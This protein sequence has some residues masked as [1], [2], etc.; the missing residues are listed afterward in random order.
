MTGRPELVLFDAGGTLVTLDPEAVGDLVEPHTG[1]RPEPALLRAAHYR[2]M[3]DP[4]GDPRNFEGGVLQW[5][6]WWLGRILAESGV[7][8][9]PGAVAAMM[10]ARGL[11]QAP[12]PG[13]VAGVR[14]VRDAGYRVAVISNADG[15]VRRDLHAAGF[16]GLFEEVFDSTLLGVSK[17]DPRIFEIA[18]TRLAVEA[19]AAWYVGDSLL[20]DV[21]GARAA[22]LAEVVLV[23]PYGLAP[24]HEPRVASVAELPELLAAR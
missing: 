12:L 14:A 9:A 17:P 6:G 23:D 11:W 20:F 15:H 3:N 19:G 10:A 5:W 22:G 16:G 13:A 2:V 24:P 4:E 21:G 7:E 1:S 8:P 18:L